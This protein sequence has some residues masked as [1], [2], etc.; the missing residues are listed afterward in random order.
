V[1]LLVPPLSV[2]KNTRKLAAGAG[3]DS[4]EKLARGEIQ[5]A[6]DKEVMEI[7]ELNEV[8]EL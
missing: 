1:A 5:S 7:K 8:K 4:V 3:V 2:A 6:L